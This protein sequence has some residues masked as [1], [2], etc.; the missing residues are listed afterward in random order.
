M[1]QRLFILSVSIISVMAGCA[2]TITNKPFDFGIHMAQKGLW[3]EAAFRWQKQ[4]DQTGPS[5][6]ILNNLAI[7]AESEGDFPKA[8]RLYQE[9]LKLAP[10]DPVILDNQA[11][12][13]KLKEG[14]NLEEENQDK[15]LPGRP[16][17]GE[18][19]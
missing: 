18:R 13:M 16:V 11:E 17:R 8:E 6:A 12:F 3:K 19:K 7:A 15:K 5:A 4:M 14:K 2:P 1:L 10:G 9:A